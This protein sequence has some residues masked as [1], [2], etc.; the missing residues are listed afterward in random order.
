MTASTADSLLIANSSNQFAQPVQ[1][2][3]VK[4]CAESFRCQGDGPAQYTFAPAVAPL[5]KSRYRAVLCMFP[6]Q[7]AGA[8]EADK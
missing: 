3:T 4:P 5:Q 2:A 8:T 6:K 7:R 1:R